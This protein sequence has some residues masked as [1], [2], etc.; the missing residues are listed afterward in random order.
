M[1]FVIALEAA[2]P[3]LPFLG[4]AMVAAH[5]QARRP[6]ERDRIRGYAIAAAVV[7]AVAALLLF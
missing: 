5:P 4:M 6:P 2:V 7:A 3:A 1:V